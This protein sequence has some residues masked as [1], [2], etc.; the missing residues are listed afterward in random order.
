MNADSPVFL[1]KADLQILIDLL[2]GQGF[3]VIGPTV[4]QEAIVYDRI[5]SIE[6]LPQGWTDRQEPGKYRLERRDDDELFGFVVGPHSWKRYLFPPLTTLS[7]ADLS[8]NG[9]QMRAAD[10]NPPKPPG[11]RRSKSRH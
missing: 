1:A 9:W 5:R 3:E 6:D 2:A 10:D 4:S 7:T 11:W 8:S